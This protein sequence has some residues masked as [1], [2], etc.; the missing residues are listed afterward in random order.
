[1]KRIVVGIVKQVL[2]AAL[3]ITV[4]GMIVGISGMV[5]VLDN[6]PDLRVWHKADLDEEFSVGSEVATFT[7]YL[8]LE[9]RLFAQLQEEVYDKVEPADKR[10]LNRYHRRGLSDLKN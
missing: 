6:R 5:M 7:D 10:E 3:Y 4:G 9:E 1:M 2:W 8:A